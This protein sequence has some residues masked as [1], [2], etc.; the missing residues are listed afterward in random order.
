MIFGFAFVRFF[1]YIADHSIVGC[2]SVQLF[3]TPGY[4]TENRIVLGLVQ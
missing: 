1:Y 4:Q 2:Y 3:L